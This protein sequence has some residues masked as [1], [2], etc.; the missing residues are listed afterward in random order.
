MSKC[1]I[2]NNK[3]D[4]FVNK[5]I[6]VIKPTGTGDPAGFVMEKLPQYYKFS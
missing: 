5:V 2:G 6:I 4:I 3:A 1:S